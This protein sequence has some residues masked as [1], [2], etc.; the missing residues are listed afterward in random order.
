MPT[1]RIPITTAKTVTIKK[2]ASI[3]LCIFPHLQ[4]FVVIDARE[5]L[6]GRPA[7]VSLRISEV[8]GEQFYSTVIGEGSEL[9]KRPDKPLRKSENF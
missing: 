8:L 9:L 5:G 6:P 4:D 3:T 2:S 7:I 1:Q